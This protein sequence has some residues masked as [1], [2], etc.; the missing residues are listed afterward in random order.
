MPPG[1]ETVRLAG[2]LRATIGVTV[3]TETR[4]L[5][6]A[7]ARAWDEIAAEWDAALLDL[8]SVDPDEGWPRRRTI[9]RATRARQAMTATVDQMQR[10]AAA[11]EVNIVSAAG[12]VVDIEKLYQPR[13]VAS[14]LPK[15][16]GTT[17]SL[18]VRFDR[19]DADA[20]AQ[21]VARSTEQ[22]T[23]AARPLSAEASEAVR[24]SV[25]RGVAAGESPRV[26]AAAM[27][28]R[29]EAAFNG[30]LTRAL[31]IARTEILDA[32]RAAA[33]IQQQANA[34]VLTGWVWTADLSSRTCPSCIAQHGSVHPLTDPGPLDHQQGR[35]AR[36]P[37]TKSWRQ[38]GFDIDE[39]PSAVPDARE[40]FAS[41]PADTQLAIMGPSRL[42][43]LQSGGVG[44]DDLSARRTTDGWRDSYGV[45]PVR[46][47]S[48]AKAA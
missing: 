25:I 26:T 35:C 45:T 9:A 38:L 41:Q 39:P 32:S 22:I 23:A 31:T 27:V 42:E 13:L 14:Q 11:A 18:A 29:V 3:D 44:W 36:T 5:V 46:D 40:W 30:G 16:A 37:V 17:A 47:L 20:L 24:R 43:A 8:A 21:I 2:E 28:R 34:D 33:A 4:K 7:W 10:L 48:A 15:T 1:P 6:A 12:D 19:V